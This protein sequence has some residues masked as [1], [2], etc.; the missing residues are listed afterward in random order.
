MQIFIFRSRHKRNLYYK[1]KYD[2]LKLKKTK[3]DQ[4]IAF[5][6]KE[7]DDLIRKRNNKR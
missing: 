4:E 1:E 2:K 5:L 6:Q 7:F 3:M